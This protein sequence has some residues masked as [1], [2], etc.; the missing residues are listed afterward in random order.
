VAEK[1]S[2][3]G[4][5][6]ASP[7]CAILPLM[8]RPFAIAGLLLAGLLFPLAGPAAAGERAYSAPAVVGPHPAPWRYTA[9]N[10][11]PFERSVRAQTIWDYG[12]CWS[13]CGAY[14]AWAL[15]SCLYEDT[16]GRCLAYTDACDRYCQRSCRSGY[17][18]PFV[19]IE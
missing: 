6:P 9:P 18:G 11:L 13:E 3:T 12:A 7:A 8:A 2:R 1:S 15:N 16:Q 5:W 17:G 19:P 4:S 10:P 14:C